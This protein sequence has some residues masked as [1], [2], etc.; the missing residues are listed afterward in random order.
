MTFECGFV[1]VMC[2]MLFSETAVVAVIVMR[3]RHAS[4][5]T[6]CISIAKIEHV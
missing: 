5:S 1:D 6:C 2:L 4:S 3:V